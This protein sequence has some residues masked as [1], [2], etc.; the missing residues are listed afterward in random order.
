MMIFEGLN[1]GSYHLRAIGIDDLDEKY[2]Q[3]LNNSDHMRWSR[4]SLIKHD[5]HSAM[6]YIDELRSQGS[7]VGVYSFN[8]SILIG[9]ITI[10]IKESSAQLGFLIFPHFSKQGILSR[11]L[12]TLKEELHRTY[13][14]ESLYIGTNFRNLAMRRVA[15][16]AG[17]LEVSAAELNE[18]LQ[19]FISLNEDVSH[20]ISKGGSNTSF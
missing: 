9:T 16:K 4:Q 7:F 3:A 6:Q 20:Y 2:Y 8:S 12:P 10:R 18:S 5:V 1:I 14:L 15:T 11:I 19:P 13:K 17:F